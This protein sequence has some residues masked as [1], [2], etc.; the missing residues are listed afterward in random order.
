MWEYVEHNIKC[1]VSVG[2]QRVTLYLLDVLEYVNK[3]MVNML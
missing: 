1:Y 2:V 3:F